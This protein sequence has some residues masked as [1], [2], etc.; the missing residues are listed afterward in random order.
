M[1]YCIYKIGNL[2]I[3]QIFITFRKIKMFQKFFEKNKFLSCNIFS[4]D[5]NDTHVNF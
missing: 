1:L 4:G 5:T 3:V 2:K